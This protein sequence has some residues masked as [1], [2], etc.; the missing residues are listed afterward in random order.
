MLLQTNSYIVPK[1]KRTVVLNL[2]TMK[3]AD[4]SWTNWAPWNAYGPTNLRVSLLPPL[5]V[6][7]PPC[8]RP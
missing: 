6:E 2:K 8:H 7:L 5:T 1:E 4:V 3:V